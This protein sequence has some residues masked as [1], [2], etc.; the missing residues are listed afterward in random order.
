MTE[1]EYGYPDF[2]I[3]GSPDEIRSR[4]SIMR[5]RA[6]DF[7]TLADSLRSVSTDG[8]VGRAAD[9]FHERFK[10]EPDRW[11]KAANGFRKAAEALDSYA[12]SLASAQAD[13]QICK[14]NFDAANVRSAQAKADYDRSVEEGYRKKAEWESQNGPGTYTLTIEPF[15]DPGE[16]QRSKAVTDYFGLCDDMKAQGSTAAA[17]VRASCDGADAA[18]NWLESG[19]AFVGGILLGAYESLK[20]ASDFVFDIQFGRTLGLV[21]DLAR[22]ATGDLTTEEW[23]AKMQLP[24]K[25]GA[26]VLQ[27]AIADP[28]AFGGAVVDSILDMDNL[29]DDPARAIGGY[30]PDLAL[31][32]ATF[33]GSGA[34]SATSKTAGSAS[35]V[36]EAA[37][38]AR[39]VKGVV[40][41]AN[42]AVDH[43]K[44]MDQELDGK[45]RQD[46]LDSVDEATQDSH[47]EGL[48]DMA[49]SL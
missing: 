16:A 24:A 32:A 38:T 34:A 35:R 15:Q 28:K 22:V 3:K 41:D 31:A 49:E 18:R 9:R 43:A 14:Q 11:T 17:T 29:K 5:E 4:T 30:I 48:L 47:P 26:A 10:P 42:K 2:I 45:R 12:D 8:W 6:S 40:D 44:A 21:S 19:V 7:D 46:A 36:A 27:A 25:E 33:G 39:D 37:K 20:K 13:A 1:P 23:A